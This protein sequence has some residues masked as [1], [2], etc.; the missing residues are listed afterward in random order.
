M[1]TTLVIIGKSLQINKPYLDYIDTQISLHVEAPTKKI[2]L[3]KTD[4]NLFDILENI[5]DEADQVLLLASKDTF[6][7][8]NKAICTINEDVLEVKDNMLLP[9][10][11][12]L[13]KNGSFLIDYKNKDINIIEAI[14]NQT[15]PQIL[16]TC[17][18]ESTLF[19]LIG[20]DEDSTKILLSPLAD[21]YEVKLTSSSLIEGWSIIEAQANKYGDLENFLKAVQSLFPEK[22]IQNE[23]VIEHIVQSLQVAD[24]TVSVAES[25]TG[26]QIASMITKI[27]G[28]SQV[29]NGSVVSYSNDIKKAWL[30]VSDETFKSY[31]AV[32]E[33]CVREM[34][35]GTLKTSL[36]DFAMATS[37]IAGPEGGTKDKPVGTV[38]VGARDKAGNILVE[39]LLLHGNRNYIQKQSCYHA[40]KLLLEVGKDFF[41]KK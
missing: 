34:M 11:A 31:G 7:L 6:N 17:K 32:S 16:L 9:S 20:I 36:A 22:F 3:D 41:F 1:A 5:L 25:C 15:L 10:K 27:S 12:K 19:S 28:S 13:Y 4:N 23:N 26:G 24:K 38:Y 14:E 40:F 21:T 33:L 39:R 29:F 8:V 35:E 30:G 2:F 18:S 37:G